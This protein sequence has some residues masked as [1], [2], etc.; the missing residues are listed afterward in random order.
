MNENNEDNYDNRNENFHHLT[1][2]TTLYTDTSMI[3]HPNL[4]ETPMTS[5]QMYNQHVQ[6]A[7][8]P[9]SFPTFVKDVTKP[10]TYH[11]V[12]S[13]ANAN[14]YYVNFDS[15]EYN[16]DGTPNNQENPTFEKS[17]CVKTY[18]CS[19]FGCLICCLHHCK[20]I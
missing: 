20:L 12:S 2:L 4:S 14:N 18:F 15:H 13:S 6:A 16:N 17:G 3:F 19:L 9:T 7:A 1:N 5:N 11:T 10:F 8:K